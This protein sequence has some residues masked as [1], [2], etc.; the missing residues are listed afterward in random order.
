MRGETDRA[1]PTSNRFGYLG[2]VAIR[3][4]QTT[5]PFHPAAIT[6]LDP[7]MRFVYPFMLRLHRPEGNWACGDCFGYLQK[8]IVS[9]V[10]AQV[11]G[12]RRMACYRYRCQQTPRAVLNKRS[13]FLLSHAVLKQVPQVLSANITDRFSPSGDATV[14]Y[15]DYPPSHSR[16]VLSSGYLRWRPA[17]MSGVVICA[18]GRFHF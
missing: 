17:P 14:R 9:A 1:K 5:P 16:Q 10:S 7:V 11:V 2:I 8:W 18:V 12:K 6:T 3:I 4:G 15:R 13:H